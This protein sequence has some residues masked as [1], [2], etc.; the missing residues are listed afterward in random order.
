ME[1]GLPFQAAVNV[2]SAHLLSRMDASRTVRQAIDES[3]GELAADVNRAIVEERTVAIVS[4]ML[5]LG[6]LH[7]TRLP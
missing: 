7:P 1:R 6:F 4:R 5:E 2:Y 3:I